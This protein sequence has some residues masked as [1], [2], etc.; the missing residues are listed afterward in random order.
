[1]ERS[2]QRLIDAQRTQ[3][4]F[5]ELARLAKPTE[6][7]R[8]A[9]FKRFEFSFETAWKAAQAHLADRE[10]LDCASPK[11]CIRRSREVGLLTDA[12]TQSALEMTDDR[13]AAAHLYKESM[14]VEMFPRL[15]AHSALRGRRVGA[16]APEAGRRA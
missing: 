3:A 16:M 14:A 13:N 1:M 2:R 11:S 8:D 12:D 4:A 7:E 5:D 15:A 6:V 10:G 9:A